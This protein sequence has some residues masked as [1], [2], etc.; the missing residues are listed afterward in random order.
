MNALVGWLI[1]FYFL[2]ALFLI[3]IALLLMSVKQPARRI[4]LTWA[5][6]GGIL[7]LALACALPQWPKTSLPLVSHLQLEGGETA[8]EPTFDHGGQEAM[9]DDLR[10]MSLEPASSDTASL[11]TAAEESIPARQPNQP[12]KQPATSERA[13]PL[14]PVIKALFL[15]G[16]LLAGC[17][18]AMGALLTRR[19][20]RGAWIAPERIQITM[21]RLLQDPMPIPRVF[22]TSKVNQ[23][24]AVGLFRPCI[25][26]P[27]RFVTS[28]SKESLESVLTHESAHIRNG[29]LWLL[30]AMRL[31]M[32]VLFAHPL[33]W[34]L[35]A[36]SRLDQE[37]LA[38][39]AA[40]SRGDST[41]Y[42]E[43]LLDW[44]KTSQSDQHRLATATLGLWERPHQLKRRIAML[45]NMSFRVETQ[46]PSR[47]RT[48]CWSVLSVVLVGLSVVTLR[49]TPS[50]SVSETAAKQAGR[51]NLKSAA[52]AHEKPATRKL[53]SFLTDPALLKEKSEPLADPATEAAF[54]EAD[55]P[56]ASYQI[57]QKTVE[58]EFQSYRAAMSVAAGFYNS[59]NLKAAQA[60]LEAALKLATRDMDKRRAHEALVGVYAEAGE[61]DR[62]FES[63]EFVV[64]HT[65]HHASKGMACRKLFLHV[66][67]KDQM[68]QAKQ[69][70]EKV[71]KADPKDR[72]ALFMLSHYYYQL[73]RD[74]STRAKYLQR[75]V[76]LDAEKGLHPGLGADLA[77]SYGLSG[78]YVKAAELFDRLTTIDEDAKS[79][80]FKEAAKN[81]ANAKQLDKAEAAAVEAHQL[82]PDKRTQLSLDSWHVDLGDV[83]I[84]IGAKDHAI[85][86]LEEAIKASKSDFYKKQY[87]EKLKQAH[88]LR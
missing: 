71:L 27:E 55:V 37:L 29:D 10:A 18:L 39:A 28:E 83:F 59:G 4:S 14:L 51:V 57:A 23:A 33:Y 40:G 48:G 81:W 34:W 1:D 38:D 61:F 6:V 75:L 9:G 77:F 86:H 72:L 26:L 87:E 12:T 44:F 43:L 73:N 45:L 15:T 11:D 85:S 17:W 13:M 2:T 21:T 68:K 22:V 58:I 53:T 25:L 82:G 88:E 20:R 70:Y 41:Q 79:W 84:K 69:R 24:L 67:R 60:P 62:M 8:N 36:Q 66:R 5:A 31:L 63:A 7:I 47:W 42:A 3:V 30:A 56:N 54:Q 16:G 80:N 74:H 64:L 52:A 49:G 32:V 78:E 50:V 46:C 76:D 35:R 19:L 65:E